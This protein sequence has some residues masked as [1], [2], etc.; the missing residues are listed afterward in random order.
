MRRKKESKRMNRIN[1]ILEIPVEVT[2]TEP[3]ITI[4]GFKQVISQ[5]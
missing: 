2:S 3:K 5:S 4:I 1:E